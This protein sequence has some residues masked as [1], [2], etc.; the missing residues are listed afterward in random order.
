MKRVSVVIPTFERPERLPPLLAALGAQ[1]LPAEDFE[2]ILADDGS[3]DDTARVLEGLAERSPLVVRIVRNTHNRGPAAARNLACAIA[4]APV[5]AFTDDDCRPAPAWLEAGLGALEAGAD[6]VQGKTI[7]DPAASPRRAAMSQQL[8]EF[9]DRYETCNIFYRADVLRAAGGFDE[10]LAF[11]GEDTV[12]GWTARRRGAK[13]TFAPEAVV[14]HAVTYPGMIAHWRRAR[15]HGEIAPTLVRRFPEMRG[16]ALWLG[17]FTKRR[18]AALLAVLA[19]LVVGARWRPALALTIPY[20]WYQRPRSRG[21]IVDRLL[22]T[23]L[24]AARVAG[25]VIGSV[26]ERTVVL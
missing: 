7:P 4:E 23:T 20:A 14:Y 19:G 15:E 24:D 12:L 16:E 22:L 8:E 10:T 13:A 2:V 26:R 9:T 25:L 11:F 17:V 1:T 5:L 3:R 21:E 6:I 18:H